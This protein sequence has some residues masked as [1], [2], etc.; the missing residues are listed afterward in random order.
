M[1]KLTLIRCEPQGIMDD[2]E[3]QLHQTLSLDP[4]GGMMVLPSSTARRQS[5]DRMLKRGIV[6]LG[7]PICT[8]D[9]LA[10]NIFED[11]CVSETSIGVEEAELVLKSV[12]DENRS[13]LKEFEPLWAGIGPTVS[14]LR[15]LFDTWRQFKVSPSVIASPG[16]DTVNDQILSIFEKYLERTSGSKLYDSVGVMEC[17]I[18][19]LKENR[20]SVKKVW[21]IGL[22]ELSPLEKELVNAV[23]T[24][25]IETVF[26]I[27]NDGGKTFREDLSW[28]GADEKAVKDC[29][30]AE[31]L[32]RFRNGAELKARV[33]ADPLA[34]ARAVAGEIRRLISSGTSPSEICV[35]LPMREKS[36][37]LFREMLDESGI[38]CN[39]D[40]PIPLN[41]SPIVHVML[42][43][44]EAVNEDMPRERVVRLLSSPYIRFRYGNESKERL[45]GGM[46]S[47]YG[48]QAGVI[49]GVAQWKEK[50]DLLRKSLEEEASS[51]EVPPERARQISDK[52]MRVA[53]VNDGLTELFVLL[54]TIKGT[55]TVDERISRLKQVLKRLEAD[56]HLAHEDERIYNKE[57]R[58]L[59]A[60]FGVLDTMISSE[61]FN[62]VG[63]EGLGSFIARVKVLCSNS[64]HYVEPMYD[65]AVQVTGLR[66][67]ML[68]RY[69]HVFIVGMIEGDLPFLGVGNPFIDEADIG[70][71]G[72]LSRSDILRQERLY[73][74]SA[75]ETARKTVSLSCYRSNDGSKVVSS[76]FYDEVVKA[77]DPPSFAEEDVHASRINEQKALGEAIARKR[78]MDGIS[79]AIQITPEELLRRI[80]VEAFHRVNDYD[81]PFDGVLNDEKII[82]EL[83][84]MLSPAKVFSPTQIETYSSCPFRFFLTSVLRIEPRPELELEITGKDQGTFVHEVAFRLY[85][86]LRSSGT[87]MNAENLDSIEKLAKAIAAAELATMKFSGP[88]WDAFQARMAGSP[89]RKGLL[90]AFLEYEIA[91]PSPYTPSLFELS[92]G[93]AKP[94]SCDPS[95]VDKP[96]ELDLGDDSKLLLAGRVDRVDIDQDGKFLVIDYKTGMLP[97]LSDV[98]TG[99]SLQ[100]QL[101]LQAVEKMIKDSRGVGGIFYLVKNEAEVEYSTIVVD[102]ENAAPLKKIVGTRKHFLSEP[103]GDLVAGTNLM[104]AGMLSNMR[105]GAFHPAESEKDCKAYCEFKQVCRF[106]ALRV[107]DMEGE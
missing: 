35:M 40:V 54:G 6:L 49:G 96:V 4:F 59:A 63:K 53:T 103:I 41:Q 16:K 97:K 1:G 8:L 27:R 88:A 12:M 24:A 76:S 30:K 51:P 5:V 84:K 20:V 69:D 21:M 23:R 39:L 22:N 79:L 73:F 9:E 85:S 15:A 44:L 61:S 89:Y 67:A 99:R 71:M 80:N 37:P 36:A 17:A 11:C 72:L 62:P 28:L 82:E 107:M 50:M 10:K 7:D 31:E 70:R 38:W 105:N 106:D 32:A 86:Q 14:E 92:F 57:A 55:I 95:S 90:R 46:V 33:F 100:V 65:D 102:E 47:S 77:L 68:T 83:G 42:D 66:A 101:Y 43:L 3:E 29:P 75:L 74:L 52:A 78:S 34:E 25:A 91:N 81:S 98:E 104:V 64:K 13:S 58:S 94:D 60:F 48:E 2:V 87:P 19:W 93:R 26:V 45:S 18:R 56:R